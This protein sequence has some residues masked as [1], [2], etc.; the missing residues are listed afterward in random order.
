MTHPQQLTQKMKQENQTD[1]SG[2]EQKH[3]E[4]GKAIRENKR[5]ESLQKGWRHSTEC[6]ETIW[7]ERKAFD[8]R[9]MQVD[10]DEDLQRRDWEDI[11]QIMTK[12]LTT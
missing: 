3:N 5:A 7:R 6:G 9:E 4:L 12:N 1:I 10:V 2:K 8:E 11:I